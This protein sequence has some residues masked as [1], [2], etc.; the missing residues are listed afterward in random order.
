MKHNTF[1]FNS[2][3]C[4]YDCFPY[5]IRRSHKRTEKD[6]NSTIMKFSLDVVCK[7]VHVQKQSIFTRTIEFDIHET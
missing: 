1:E 2:L 3:K 7:I 4:P 6:Y 5:S